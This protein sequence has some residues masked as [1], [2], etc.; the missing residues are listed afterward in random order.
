MR[1]ILFL[2]LTFAALSVE[3][4]QVEPLTEFLNTQIPAV[5]RALNEPQD[6]QESEWEL[7]NFYLRFITTVNFNIFYIVNL[8]IEPQIEL[9]WHH[10]EGEK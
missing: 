6:D 4:K 10:I 9:V 1:K 8:R 7:R 3:A 5:N 2:L